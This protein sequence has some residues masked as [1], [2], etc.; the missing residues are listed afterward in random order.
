MLRILRSPIP[1]HS[2]LSSGQN[3]PGKFVIIRIVFQ[4]IPTFNWQ[5]ATHPGVPWSQELTSTGKRT[6]ATPRCWWRLNE[7][8]SCTLCNCGE[9]HF[10]PI[11]IHKWSWE[12]HGIPWHF[13]HLCAQS[14]WASLRNPLVSDCAPAG[15]CE[16]VRVLIEAAADVNRRTLAGS[17]PLYQAC[18]DGTRHIAP[19]VADSE[20]EHPQH[21]GHQSLH[22]CLCWRSPDL[23]KL[24]LRHCDQ[25]HDGSWVPWLLRWRP[26]RTLSWWSR[27][28][29]WCGSAGKRMTRSWWLEPLPD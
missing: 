21:L 6:W 12:H 25:G 19:A 5:T 23:V 13:V 7:V 24:L 27:C 26:W 17:S 16:A 1:S 18:R 10:A 11:N 2:H 28:C 14:C 4:H 15:H 8:G 3:G 9:W 20:G 22:R 29:G